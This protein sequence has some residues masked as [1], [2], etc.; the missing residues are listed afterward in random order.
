MRFKNILC[1]VDF[2][3]G[4]RRALDAAVDLARSNGASLTIAHVV[5]SYLYDAP[6]ALLSMDVMRAIVDDDDER[7]SSWRGIAIDAG[8]NQVE[9]KML[10]GVAWDQIVHLLEQDQT[11]DL[12]VMGNHGRTDSRTRYSARSPS[13]WSATRDVPH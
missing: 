6:E 4:S 10:N 2:S 1:P 7:L 12:V 5:H 3:D 8:I 11:F 9:A 13:E